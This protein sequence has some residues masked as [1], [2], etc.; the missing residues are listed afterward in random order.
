MDRRTCKQI[1]IQGD[2][3]PSCHLWESGDCKN[4]AVSEKNLISYKEFHDASHIGNR[5]LHYE[6]GCDI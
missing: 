2:C 4:E 1:Q 5:F 3:G 6:K